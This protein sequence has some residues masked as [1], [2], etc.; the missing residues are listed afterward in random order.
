MNFKESSSVF[1]PLSD[2]VVQHGESYRVV[3]IFL[4]NS[5]ER[6]THVNVPDSSSE[7]AFFEQG[8]S[9]SSLNLM[10]Y[11]GEPTNG[12]TY[13]EA[14]KIVKDKYISGFD[15]TI[16]KNN[17]DLIG[18]SAATD[19]AFIRKYTGIEGNSFQ[20]PIENF[21]IRSY[22]IDIDTYDYFG[23]VN[24]ATFITKNPAA[25]A[26]IL[27]Y[28]NVGGVLD[29]SYEGSSD[30]EHLR[31]SNYSGLLES[32][33][34]ES[35]TGSN[36]VVSVPLIPNLPNYFKIEPYDGFGYSEPISLS[37]YSLEEE[38]SFPFKLKIKSIKLN[39]KDGGR[40]V[41]FDMQANFENSPYVSAKYK[42]LTSGNITGAEIGYDDYLYLD[43]GEFNNTD[44][45]IKNTGFNYTIDNEFTWQ[46]SISSG[47]LNLGDDE[48][49]YAYWDS[50]SEEVKSISAYAV[51]SG[52][53]PVNG[54]FS[55]PINEPN[56]YDIKFRS[57]I[58]FKGEYEKASSYL[59][60]IGEMPA[61]IIN[62]SQANKLKSYDG[63]VGWLGLRKGNVGLLDG[64]FSE[65]QINQNIFRSVNFK[66]QA[67]RVFSFENRARQT[68]EVNYIANDIGTDW[69]WVNSSGTQI[70]KYIS[71][72]QYNPETYFNF[73]ID[74]ESTI[75]NDSTS[76]SRKLFVLPIDLSDISGSIS[77]ETLSVDYSMQDGDSVEYV[78][79]HT[80]SSH[81]F[82]ISQDNFAKQ[83]IYEDEA[84]FDYTVDKKNAPKYFKANFFDFLGNTDTV[85]IN[86]IYY[87]TLGENEVSELTFSTTSQTTSFSLDGLVGQTSKKAEV[88][89]MMNHNTG[90]TIEFSMN[91]TGNTEEP[92]FI[93]AM[94][95]GQP[96]TSG[97]C[98]LLDRVPPENGYYL[99][100]LSVDG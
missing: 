25:S 40:S 73:S 78:N 99:N 90:P 12:G 57:G 14:S 60:T 27:S 44:L 46:N 16:Y 83:Y 45:N 63:A 3:S 20:Y 95:F 24:T 59:N 21:S 91:Y 100:V 74:A 5:Q 36:G 47:A 9:D 11:V 85:D 18:E 71:G 69:A 76:I 94:I 58:N 52:E 7:R 92:E 35:Y 38:K 22:S 68:E 48:P 26:E 4:T 96:T 75:S 77:G 39:K 70:Y 87:E 65:N 72:E 62:E 54:M 2:P 97:A 6:I 98:F 51:R 41:E 28:E 30:L 89:F 64:L 13:K 88:D 86:K 42:V 84:S 55:M 80:G 66:D 81:D 31:V 15:V 67:S 37:G 17:R 1:I 34:H 61:V 19:R 49:E 23:N 53:M 82:E 43:S 10:W 32:S 93:N 79:L 33:F 50:R 29:I 8:F 56:S